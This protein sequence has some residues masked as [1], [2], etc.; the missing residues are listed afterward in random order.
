MSR[1]ERLV[2]WLCLAAIVLAIVLYF[3]GWSL[4]GPG[5]TVIGLIIVG[6]GVAAIIARRRRA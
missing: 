3:G 2:A 6:A 4:P 5:F 1:T